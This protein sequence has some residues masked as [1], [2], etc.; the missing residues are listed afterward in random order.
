MCGFDADTRPCFFCI[1]CFGLVFQV[2]RYWECKALGKTTHSVH[3]DHPSCYRLRMCFYLKCYPPLWMLPSPTPSSRQRMALE[4]I[5]HGRKKQAL[6]LLPKKMKIPLFVI[7]EQYPDVLVPA[8]NK[9]LQLR[10]I[11]WST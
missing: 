7:T 4:T 8:A 9:K 2:R 5:P 3:C 6:Q 10:E 11:D 1:Y